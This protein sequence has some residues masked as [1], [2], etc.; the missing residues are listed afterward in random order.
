[1]E[2]YEEKRKVKELE[3]FRKLY[4]NLKVKDQERE[5]SEIQ[6]KISEEFKKIK[7]R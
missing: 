4:E 5:N 2:L 3:K 6:K 7:E 1:M